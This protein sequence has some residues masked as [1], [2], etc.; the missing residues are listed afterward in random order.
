MMACHRPMI[1]LADMEC[2]TSGTGSD[3]AV[4]RRLTGD[5]FSGRRFFS[6]STRPLPLALSLAPDRFA[7]VSKMAPAIANSAISGFFHDKN[8]HKPPASR[9]RRSKSEDLR[10]TPFFSSLASG[11][12]PQSLEAWVLIS[13]YLRRITEVCFV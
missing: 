1:L 10:L 12:L 4:E 8:S 13:D 11:C 3:V 9:L 2:V 5:G 7:R 6:R